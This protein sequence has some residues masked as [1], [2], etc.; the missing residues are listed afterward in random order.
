[1]N[2]EQKLLVTATKETKHRDLAEKDTYCIGPS[3]LKSKNVIREVASKFI[4]FKKHQ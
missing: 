4:D 2:S 3:T 1:M